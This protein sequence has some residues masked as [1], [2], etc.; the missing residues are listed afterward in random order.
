[1]LVSLLALIILAWRPTNEQTSVLMGRETQ[2]V[3]DNGTPCSPA[4]YPDSMAQPS[5][6][7]LLHPLCHTVVVVH[8]HRATAK[9]RVSGDWN[10]FND[11]RVEGLEAHEVQAASAYVLFY[12]KVSELLK[13]P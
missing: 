4:G 6:S 7:A 3:C 1:M 12:T 8:V 2:L 5:I 11:E 9:N 10:L 13:L